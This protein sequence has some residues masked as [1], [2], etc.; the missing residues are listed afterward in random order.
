MSIFQHK[1]CQ[2]MA[3]LVLKDTNKSI[4][5]ELYLFLQPERARFVKKHNYNIT[6]GAAIIATKSTG[7]PFI[8]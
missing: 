5:Q 6:S 2:K 1:F 7:F 8:S 4:R 3:K